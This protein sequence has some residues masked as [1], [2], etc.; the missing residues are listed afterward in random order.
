MIRVKNYFFILTL[1]LQFNTVLAFEDKKTFS[2]LSSSLFTISEQ[3]YFNFLRVSIL[4]QPEYLYSVSEVNEKDMFLRFAK[5]NR[6][7]ELSMR[8]IN[9]SVLKRDIEDVT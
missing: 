3:D 1:V 4:E 5:R 2:D 6:F 8:I 9:D 7:P